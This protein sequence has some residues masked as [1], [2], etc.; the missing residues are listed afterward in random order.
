MYHLDIVRLF[1][2]VDD[3]VKQHQIQWNQILLESST[4]I[5]R[6]ETRLSLSEIMAI[7][8]LFHQSNFR[9]FKHFYFYLIRFHIEDFPDLVSYSRIVRLMPRTLL[10]LAAYCYSLKGCVSG[11][12]FID[13]T[14]IQVCKPK[15]M[16]NNRVF[17]GI[18][19]K[20]KSSIGWFFGFKLHLIVNDSG[21]ILAFTITPGNVDD[22]KPVPQLAQNLWG[23][24]FGDKG[25]I[26]KA[27]AD[28]LLKQNTSL[29][30]GIKKGMK[31]K[32]IY[33]KDKILLRKR[34][35]VE[36]IN[37]QLKNISQ[38]EHSRHRSPKNFMINIVSGIIAYAKQ[39]KKPSIIHTYV[40]QTFFP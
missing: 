11:I 7:L 16:S 35:I 2:E 22:R 17:K 26:S 20:G 1:C 27:L 23:K 29:F 28:Y 14:P 8:I 31:D 36:T 33:L 30:S 6:R 32:L 34:C 10:P 25:Y 18:A 39:S 12:S 38:I 9:T 37:D 3:F 13:S 21:E 24:L 19:K 4:Q 40:P 15:R 5:R